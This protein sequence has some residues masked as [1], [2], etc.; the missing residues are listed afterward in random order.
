[1]APTITQHHWAPFKPMVAAVERL[2][3]SK[4][5]V[6]EIGP[7]GA[8]FPKATVFVDHQ[9]WPHLADRELHVLDV[10]LHRLPF[11]DQSFDFVYC[12]HTL[13]DIYNPV[14]V[15]RE[16][17]RVGRAGYIETPS[18]IA[19]TCRG[20]DAVDTGSAPWR[21]YR[22]HRYV[23]W[24]ENETLL[25]LPKYPLIEH[26]DFGGAEDH[27]VEALNQNPMLWN[28]YFFWEGAL[29]ARLL[30][31][32]RDFEFRDYASVLLNAARQSVHH[33][34]A[35]AERFLPELVEPSR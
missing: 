32:E 9:E 24:V 30:E 23:V 10:N 35:I 2:A 18:P 22:H 4:A 26:L 27:L 1:M 13:E 20:V 7:G 14:W 29:P 8:P 17:A 16:M 3:A 5:R 15:C 33:T 11:P 6:L 19:E 31:N 25:F 12:R 28:T 34:K 21:G